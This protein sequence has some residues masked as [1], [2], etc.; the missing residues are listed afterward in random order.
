MQYEVV[1]VPVI[2][3][4]AGR[5]RRGPKKKALKMAQTRLSHT[6]TQ[7]QMFRKTWSGDHFLQVHYIDVPEMHYVEMLG[8]WKISVSSASSASSSFEFVS[9]FILL[10]VLGWTRKFN[11]VQHFLAAHSRWERKLLVPQGANLMHSAQRCN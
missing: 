9:S 3:E 10:M 6:E 8:M 2:T 1:H 7:S 5:S 4:E 11:P